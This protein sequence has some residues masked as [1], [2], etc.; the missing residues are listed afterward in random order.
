[1]RTNVTALRFSWFTLFHVIYFP[2]ILPAHFGARLTMPL[3]SKDQELLGELPNALELMKVSLHIVQGQSI[4]LFVSFV[5]IFGC[6][7]LCSIR[8]ASPKLLKMLRKT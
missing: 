1:M 8:K 3:N 7:Y 5:S 6:S 4:E 2:S